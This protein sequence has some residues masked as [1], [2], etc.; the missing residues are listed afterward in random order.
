MI[1]SAIKTALCQKKEKAMV[2]EK[3]IRPMNLPVVNIRLD[4]GLVG[5]SLK[6]FYYFIGSFALRSKLIAHIDKFANYCFIDFEEWPCSRQVCLK[7]KVKFNE[8][9]IFINI[10]FDADGTIEETYHMFDM[11]NSIQDKVFEFF[12][13]GLFCDGVSNKQISALNKR[14]SELAE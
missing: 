1:R 9:E 8:R 3:R 14:M 4:D 12:N 13:K 11:A 10:H 2:S 5:I 6:N 7:L